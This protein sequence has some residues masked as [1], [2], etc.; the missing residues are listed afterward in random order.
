MNAAARP[1]AGGISECFSCRVG[2]QWVAFPVAQVLEVITQQRLTPMPLAPD[3]VLGLINLRGRIISEVDVRRILGLQA[4]EAERHVHVVIVKSRQ[5]EDVGLVVDQVG[6]V[7]AIDYNR[8][9]KVPDTLHAVWQQI[10][11][12]VLK[13][14]THI[15]VML[16]V[17]R[18]LALSLPCAAQEPQGKELSRSAD[19]KKTPVVL[20]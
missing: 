13:Y 9:E 14:D 19:G 3:G 7:S 15:T 5:G 20:H 6:A 8:F 16:D 1:R 10:G 12:G 4:A 2:G 17:D 18:L 11:E